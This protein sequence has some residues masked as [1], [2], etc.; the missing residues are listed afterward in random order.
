MIS[1]LLIA[2]GAALLMVGL[3]IE[4]LVFRAIH[5]DPPSTYMLFAARDKLIRLVI[6]GKIERREPHF[7]AL[8]RNINIMLKGCR[9]LSG[10]EGWE[11]AEA[12]GI[13]LARHPY[14]HVKL[15]EM[16]QKPAPRVLDEVSEELR[17]SL[18]HLVRN[19]FGIFVV[20]DERRRELERMQKNRAKELL[21]IMRESELGSNH[22]CAA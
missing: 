11:R 10:P 16:P 20:W 17:D 9:R 4:A 7:D 21:K 3:L 19:H 12:D 6:D 8:Y 22:R 18:E 2:A 5:D 1:P 14:D 13:Y 15:V